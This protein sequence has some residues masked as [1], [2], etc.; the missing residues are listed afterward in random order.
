MFL[1]NMDM[2][3]CSSIIG[4]AYVSLDFSTMDNSLTAKPTERHRFYF[5][6]RK[7]VDRSDWINSIPKPRE[8]NLANDDGIQKYMERMVVFREDEES[9]GELDGDH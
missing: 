2:I 9:N 7:W 8:I 5:I 1:C 6:D 4:H 3:D